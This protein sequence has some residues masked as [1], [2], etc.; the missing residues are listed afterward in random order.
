MFEIEDL[1][2]IL[3]L[4]S[5]VTHPDEWIPFLMKALRFIE[6]LPILPFIK[7]RLSLAVGWTKGRGA[8]G[9]ALEN[10]WY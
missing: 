4:A 8:G 5:L 1:K 3:V 7:N 2:R 9:E 6:A 10:R